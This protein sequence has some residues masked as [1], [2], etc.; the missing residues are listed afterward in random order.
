[1]GPEERELTPDEG[2]AREAVRALPSVQAD[3][4][5][6]ERLKADFVAGR[7]APSG[8][9]AGGEAAGSESARAEA[10]R[11][12]RTARLRAW[13]WP[14]LLAP[15]A[16]VAV[17]VVAFVFGNRGPALELVGVTGEGVVLVDGRSYDASDRAGLAAAARP[18]S[19][20]EVPEG[21]SLALGLPGKM[22]VE[23]AAATG[24]V[25]S[26]PG[27]W[28]GRSSGCGL[29]GGE[30]RVLTGA[31]FQGERFEVSTP[32]G[33]IRVT[34]TLVSAVRDESGT[35]VCVREGTALVGRSE[36][37]LRPIP[38]GKRLVLHADRSDPLFTDIAPPHE[39]HLLDFEDRYGDFVR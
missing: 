13:L 23:L 31:G 25:P 20:I 1:M 37:D 34:G 33:M 21:A 29:E 36:E 30:I 15:V 3:P 32:D 24:T 2:R 26:A 5:F 16:A 14:R 27:R 12:R 8:E 17:A 18:G 28:L 39:A 11:R 22:V 7:L 35:C 4:A 10:A 9:E 6:R 38:A 19:R